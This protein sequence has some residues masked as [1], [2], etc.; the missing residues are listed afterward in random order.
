MDATAQ[1]TKEAELYVLVETERESLAA[2]HHET[3]T[4]SR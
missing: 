4:I 3:H 1:D 2:A